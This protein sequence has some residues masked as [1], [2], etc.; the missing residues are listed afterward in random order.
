MDDQWMTAD[1]RYCYEML[2]DWLGG[3]HHVPQVKSWGMGI[4]VSVYAS[5]LST[6]DFDRLTSLVLLAHDRCVRVEIANGGPY[7]V[8]V[9]LHRRHAREGCVGMRHPTIEEALALHRRYWPAPVAA[10]G[11][12]AAEPEGISA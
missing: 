9:V 3:A 7:R 11:M 4:K 8:G 6:F 1:Q 12:I 2:C 5:G 10:Q